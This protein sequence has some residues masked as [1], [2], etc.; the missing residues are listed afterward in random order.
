MARTIEVEVWATGRGSVILAK[1]ET[2]KAEDM[3][4]I[5]AESDWGLIG[6]FELHEVDRSQEAK[7]I[8]G[9]A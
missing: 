9:A 2:R 4:V 1:P 5:E 7:W 6:V 3:R 8:R